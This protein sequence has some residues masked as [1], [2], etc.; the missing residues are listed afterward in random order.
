MDSP[1]QQLYLLRPKFHFP[2]GNS[3]VPRFF[4][5]RAKHALH[6]DDRLAV[7]PLGNAKARFPDDLPVEDH[8]QHAGFIIQVDKQHA[9]H[10]PLRA[11]PAAGANSFP[12]LLL[13]KQ[14]AVF[15]SVHTLNPP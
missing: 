12:Q 13:A 14:P 10:I 15:V 3:G 6:G 9:A 4:L 8:L 11:D 7:Q 2:R 1:G 5:P